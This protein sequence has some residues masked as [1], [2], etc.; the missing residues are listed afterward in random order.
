MAFITSLR[1]KNFFSIKDEVT[2]DFKASPYNIEN[3][4]DRLFEFNGE[5]YNKVISLYG[6][7][8]SG[9]TTVLKAIIIILAVV[10]DKRS[11]EFPL[12]FKNKFSSL[13]NTELELSFVLK[14]DSFLQKFKYKVIFKSN[15]Y[16]NIGIIDEELVKFYGKKKE[17][18]L[19]RKKE[20]VI[21]VDS[22]ITKA[23]FQN[24]N[25]KTSLIQ[26]FYKFERTEILTDIRNFF[27]DIILASN[28]KS[29]YTNLNTTDTDTKKIAEWLYGERDGETQI[30][31]FFLSFFNSIGLDIVRVKA[32]FNKEEKDLNKRFKGIDVFH[33]IKTDTPLEIYLESSGTQM[34][35][36]I[37]LDIFLA[38]K[39][40]SM[41]II[42]ELD[43]IIHPMLVPII[44]N[45]LIEND[46]QI[47][48]S[49]HN[50]YNMQFLQNDEI[51][52][53]EKDSSHTTTIKPIKDNK[54]IKGYENLLTHY[55]NGYLGGVPKIEDLI[56]KIL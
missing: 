30:E 32:K 39:I 29:L 9:K 53:I 43:S 13:S 48:Y 6:A 36:K 14:K 25:S 31:N 40:N 26:E 11:N 54:D 3:N 20:I 27:M 34:L 15:E 56:T 7:N 24:L 44:I 19:N 37:L 22:N 35:M 5:Y 4:P 10:L 8:A 33:G 49:T 18:L 41:L 12:S 38:K 47:I 21:N 45:L 23:V 52:L 16:E 2:L 46:I 51:F 50:I 17:N 1:I 42:D 55:E 28:I